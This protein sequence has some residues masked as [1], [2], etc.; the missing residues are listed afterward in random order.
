MKFHLKPISTNVKTGPIAVTTSPKE[1][2]PSICPLKDNGCYASVGPLNIHWNKVSQSER[3]DDW[4]VHIEKL[5]NLP[6]ETMIRL[7]QAGD[8]PNK[9]DSIDKEKVSDLIKVAKKHLTFTYTH[10][11]VLTNKKNQKIIK[12]A[13]D[14]GL[15][16]NLSGN[17]LKHADA[18]ISLQIGPVVSIV[19]S[20]I[21]GRVKGLTTPKGNRVVI[22][23]ATYMDNM[24]CKKCKLCAWIGREVVIGFPSHGIQK[25]KVNK[26]SKETI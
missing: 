8:L 19:D 26:I 5:L 11:P 20:S 22:C 7:N 3:G 10:S 1:T 25:K 9:H 6:N 13:N 18:L 4:N 24:S 23:P 14:N 2:C 15:C 17:N 16:I 12:H 21:S